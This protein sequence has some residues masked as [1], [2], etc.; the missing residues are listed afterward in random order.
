[1]Q[2]TLHA[3]RRTTHGASRLVQAMSAWSVKTDVLR[4]GIVGMR[5]SMVMRLRP[6]MIPSTSPPP[7]ILMKKRVPKIEYA[8]VWKGNVKFVATVDERVQ[9]TAA[10][11]VLQQ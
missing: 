4:P 8:E 6:F 2:L 9:M 3:T 1:M 10:K 11:R 7:H 5:G